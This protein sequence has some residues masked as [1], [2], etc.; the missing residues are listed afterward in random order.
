MQKNNKHT[1]MKCVIH[2]VRLIKFTFKW[3]NKI[4]LTVSDYR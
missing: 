2:T 3:E 1:Q 4:K